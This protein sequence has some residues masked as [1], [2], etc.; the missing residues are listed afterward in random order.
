MNRGSRSPV[1]AEKCCWQ[2]EILRYFE[3]PVSGIDLEKEKRDIGV[4][5]FRA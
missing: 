3:P 5:G 4:V 1:P 2:S